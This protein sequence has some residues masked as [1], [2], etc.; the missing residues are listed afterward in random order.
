[1]AEA[2]SATGRDPVLR[3]PRVKR[4]AGATRR[5]HQFPKLSRY[6]SM[7]TEGLV[8]RRSGRSR[9]EE[10]EKCTFSATIIGIVCE[11]SKAITP[12]IDP[13][14]CSISWMAALRKAAPCSRKPAMATVEVARCP[15]APRAYRGGTQSMELGA[16]HVIGADKQNRQDSRHAKRRIFRGKTG[17]RLDQVAKGLSRGMIGLLLD[18]RPQIGR[19]FGQSKRS[20][21]RS[22]F[23]NRLS[24]GLMH[25]LSL[26]A[27]LS[28]LHLLECRFGPAA[29][30]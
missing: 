20:Q 15:M 6:P 18:R 4:P 3:L 14:D 11:N 19:L 30:V 28:P 27:L 13:H 8:V 5:V 17:F 16:Q 24:L 23:A 21:A 9:S 26:L 22:L 1:M 7:G 2:G 10:R 29:I 12:G 25:R